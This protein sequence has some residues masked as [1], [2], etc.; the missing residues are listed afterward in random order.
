MD[1]AEVTVQVITISTRASAGVYQDT[2]GP[3]VVEVLEAEGFHCLDIVVVPDGREGVSAAIV[4][5]CESADVVLT[6]GGTGMHPKDTTPEATRDVLDREVPGIAQ[7]IRAASLA[8][9]PMAMLS[10]AISGIRG[11]T[12]II[13]VPGSPKGARES[14]EVVTGILA[15]AVDQLAAGDHE[16]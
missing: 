14:V 10:R 4:E 3:A 12:L 13:N 15:H 6:S 8:I 1:N 11:D 16:R 5:A 2:A 9:T 7:A